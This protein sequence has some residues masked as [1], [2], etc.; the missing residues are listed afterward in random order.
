MGHPRLLIEAWSSVER[1]PLSQS[2]GLCVPMREHWW[3]ERPTRVLEAGSVYPGLD[4]Q[5]VVLQDVTIGGNG[6]GRRG[7]FCICFPYNCLQVFKNKKLTTQTSGAR[8]ISRLC[9]L[10]L[11]CYFVGS[12]MDDSGCGWSDAVDLGRAG[13]TQSLTRWQVRLG[14]SVVGVPLQPGPSLEVPPALLCSLLIFFLLSHL[15]PRVSPKG[16]LLAGLRS[17]WAHVISRGRPWG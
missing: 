9:V 15:F 8:P 7:F 1:K 12:P 6:E 14:P 13:A 4:L 2:L 3:G 10:A 16:L 5:T 17:F 11:R